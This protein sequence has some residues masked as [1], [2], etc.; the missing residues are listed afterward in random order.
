M[1]KIQYNVSFHLFVSLNV[2]VITAGNVVDFCGKEVGPG[3]QRF[4]CL[5]LTLLI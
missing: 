5:G 3:G 4:F 2:A 1:T